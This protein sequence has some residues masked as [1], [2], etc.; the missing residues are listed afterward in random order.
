MA[1]SSSSGLPLSSLDSIKPENFDGTGFKRLQVWMRLWLMGL[2]LFW[3]LTE[4]PPA[5]LGEAMQDVVERTRLNTLRA[6]WEKTNA[7]AQARLLAVLSNRLFDIYV[8]LRE[9][10]KVW[11]ELNDKYAK[12]D[13]SNES[14]MVAS[15][16]NFRMGDARSV[17]EQIHEL[18]LIMRDLG[19]YGCVLPENLQVNAILAKLPTSWHDFV[20]VR[21]HLKQ[22]LT[23]NDLIAII[24]V[25]EK[26]KADYGGVKAPAQANLVEHKNKPRRNVKKGKTRPGFT[27]LKAN[28]MKLAKVTRLVGRR[29]WIRIDGERGL[30]SSTRSRISELQADFRQESCP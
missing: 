20:T 8:G 25:E 3:V 12:S 21:R 15:Y 29:W 23:L 6:R 2:G 17:M 22:R 1:N 24:N 4:D 18:Q 13:N 11:S 7:S 14:F 28:A 5:P 16:L 10:R 26:S 19:Q 27:G 30:S 9:A